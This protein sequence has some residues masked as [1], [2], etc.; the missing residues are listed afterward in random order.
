MLRRPEKVRKFLCSVAELVFAW[1]EACTIVRISLYLRLNRC[2]LLAEIG[3]IS[4]TLEGP[5]I[6]HLI[7][8]LMILNYHPPQNEYLSITLHL[9]LAS[10][11]K[12]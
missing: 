12:V 7:S 10:H 11:G 4:V 9:S 3:Y 1:L 5:F 6:F 8:T 2:S